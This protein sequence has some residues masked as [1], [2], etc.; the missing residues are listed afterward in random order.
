MTN[1]TR[2]QEFNRKLKQLSCQR[3]ARNV[4]DALT[5]SLQRAACPA[6]GQ[7]LGLVP[8]TSDP[9]QQAMLAA[10][11]NQMQLQAE[12]KVQRA[13]RK[14]LRSEQQARIAA[15]EATA[16]L[17]QSAPAGRH[18]G[19]THA[20]AR[21]CNPGGHNTPASC[22]ACKQPRTGHPKSGCPTHCMKCKKLKDDCL[23]LGGPHP[24]HCKECGKLKSACACT[25]VLHP[26]AQDNQP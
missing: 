3:G 23:C 4:S 2:L 10:F 5:Y 13:K 6:A 25:A 26:P 24:Q 18:H 8:P 21:A 22:G 17:Q 16:R 20:A 19:N 12:A 11:A 14:R 15:Q 7:T 9:G 1:V